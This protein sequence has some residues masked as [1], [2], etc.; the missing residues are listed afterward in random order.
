MKQITSKVC[1]FCKYDCLQSDSNMGPVNQ[2]ADE[3]QIMEK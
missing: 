2:N 3:Q 1:V